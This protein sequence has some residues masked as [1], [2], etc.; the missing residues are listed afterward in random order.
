[1]RPIYFSHLDPGSDNYALS[2]RLVKETIGVFILHTMPKSVNNEPPLSST[3][4]KSLSGEVYIE[5][6]RAMRGKHPLH[7]HNLSSAILF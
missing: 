4:F 2:R 5:S 1:M 7:L 3:E 6:D